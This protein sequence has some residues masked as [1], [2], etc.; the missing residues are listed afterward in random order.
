MDFV[1]AAVP[2]DV[3]DY[4]ILSLNVTS[5][6]LYCGYGMEAEILIH[7]EEKI[8]IKEIFEKEDARDLHVIISG[9]RVR[10]NYC[11]DYGHFKEEL[12]DF[13]RN[14]RRT[15]FGEVHNNEASS[16]PE[17]M[18]EERKLDINMKNE[19]KLVEEDDSE[20]RK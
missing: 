2:R 5:T 18:V 12:H 11:L 9:R 8:R 19:T 16:I 1:L 7:R 20:G 6:L 3:E 10:C 4:H 17:A 14:G 15:L 13:V